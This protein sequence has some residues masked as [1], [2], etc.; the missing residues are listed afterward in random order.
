M[1]PL[2]CIDITSNKKNDRFNGENFE[3]A[4]PSRELSENLEKSREGIMETTKK[5]DMPIWL[6]LIKLFC[7]T[8]GAII[9]IDAF[10]IGIDDGFI[11]V[12]NRAPLLIISGFAMLIVFAIIQF[13][14]NK[15]K[16]K[17]FK[18]ENLEE[19]IK[20]FEILNE[21]V[22]NDMGVPT[23]A[24]H[25]DII[26]FRY[27][28]KNGKIIPYAPGMSITPYLNFVFRVYTDGDALMIACDD[29]LLKFNKSE[30]KRISTV[31]KTTPLLHWTK[32]EPIKHEKFKPYKLSLNQDGNII[33]RKYHI[34]ELV[35]EGE[36]YGIYF[37]SY[38]LPVFER[39]TGL[40][41]EK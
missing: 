32:D 22:Y 27:R 9:A 30:L 10:F 36:T 2:F 39:L 13:G 5:A 8:I 1:K 3:V 15:K 21:A 19:N 16:E 14:G 18:E 26:Q 35:R 40:S 4:T 28:V 41:A 20:R 7:G 38:E 23:F 29:S 25:V 24:D 6:Y 12:F 37:P 17:V 33:I 31:K 34:L 11:T